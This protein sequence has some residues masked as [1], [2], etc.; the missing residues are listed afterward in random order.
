MYMCMY[1]YMCVCAYLRLHISKAVC[2]KKQYIVLKMLR[3]F[4]LIKNVSFV[5]KKNN[6]KNICKIPKVNNLPN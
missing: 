2:I 6:N 5:A 3:L 1:M 4:L